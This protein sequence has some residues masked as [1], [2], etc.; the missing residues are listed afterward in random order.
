MPYVDDI[1]RLEVLHR[2]EQL[3][4]AA[5]NLHRLTAVVDPSP[6]DG[7]GHWMPPHVLRPYGACVLCDPC[8]ADFKREMR[9]VPREEWDP[10]EVWEARGR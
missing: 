9:E 1:T 5:E 4:R 8:W 6:C 3:Q 7:C 2:I 10:N